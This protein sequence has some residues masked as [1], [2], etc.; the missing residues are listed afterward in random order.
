MYPSGGSQ[1][2]SR[3]WL[4]ACQASLSFTISWSLLTFM[5]IES[6]MP[7][8]H[9]I[10]CRP[11]FLLPSMFPSIRVFSNESS[12]RI[13]W[14]KYW[15]FSFSINPSNEYSGLIFSIDWFDLA[16]QGTLASFPTPQFKS[17]NSLVLSLLYQTGLSDFHFSVTSTFSAFMVQLS[18]LYITTGK[19]IALTIQSFVGKVHLLIA[20]F[21]TLLYCGKNRSKWHILLV[22]FHCW[23]LA[24]SKSY[25]LK[26]AVCTWDYSLVSVYKKIIVSL[27]TASLFS[28][29]FFLLLWSVW[30]RV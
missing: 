18:H 10:L 13:R 7:S 28:P 6:V 17:I 21:S 14:P 25:L 23:H 16:V 12:V 24:A 29:R 11:L 2:F 19:S 20:L 8:N 30:R 4:F 15:S 27:F 3:V 5:S 22:Y 9:L 1:L 26:P